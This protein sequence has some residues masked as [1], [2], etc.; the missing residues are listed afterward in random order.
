M[1]SRIESTKFDVGWH[2]KRSKHQAELEDHDVSNMAKRLKA[3]AKG[4]AAEQ[5]CRERRSCLGGIA[6]NE[7]VDEADGC[8]RRKTHSLHAR[9][10]Y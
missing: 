1:P 4:L 2:T 5:Q 7:K 3:K 9:P 6:A 8:E 10:R